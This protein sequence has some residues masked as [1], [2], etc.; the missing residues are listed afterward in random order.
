MLWLVLL[1]LSIFFYGKLFLKLF[2]ISSEGI[3][4][5]TSLDAALI[6]TINCSWFLYFE[7]FI[8]KSCL[9]KQVLR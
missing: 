2:S 4:L 3:I 1:K 5:S 9:E 6:C 8:I 7:E